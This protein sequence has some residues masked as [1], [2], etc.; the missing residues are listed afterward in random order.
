MVSL[1]QR[2]GIRLESMSNQFGDFIVFR[3]TPCLYRNYST[4]G[5]PHQHIETSDFLAF[6]AFQNIH[7]PSIFSVDRFLTQCQMRIRGKQ[8]GSDVSH[9]ILMN[10]TLLEPSLMSDA[11]EK[12]LPDR[13]DAPIDATAQRISVD[14]NANMLSSSLS[15]PYLKSSS[16]LEFS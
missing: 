9:L 12:A 14:K 7:Q 6:T 3:E 11:A 10:R 15:N 2:A 4:C 5:K 1:V 8:F 13:R 16:G